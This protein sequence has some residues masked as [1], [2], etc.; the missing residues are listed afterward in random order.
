MRKL[1]IAL[2]CAGAVLIPAQVASASPHTVHPALSGSELCTASAPNLVCVRDANDSNSPGSPIVAG[3]TDIHGT[4]EALNML[5]VSGGVKL[6]FAGHTSL[7]VSLASD[8]SSFVTGDC[9]TAIGTVFREYT[10]NGAL[11]FDNRYAD[12]HHSGEWDLTTTDGVGSQ[13]IIGL[14]GSFYQRLINC[15]GN[16][17]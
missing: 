7:C 8:G 9:S 6:Q 10:L 15:S 2:I 16:C 12:Q 4:A 1:A 5:V 3:D 14:R 11:V 17:V 13:W